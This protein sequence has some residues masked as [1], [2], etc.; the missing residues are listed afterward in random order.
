MYFIGRI[1]PAAIAFFGIALY[2]RF[3]DPVSFGTYALLLSTSFL[4]GT[5]C[6]SWLRVAALRMMGTVVASDEA[7]YAATIAASFAGM[8]VLVSIIL[9]VSLHFYHLQLSAT[10]IALTV[11]GAVMSGWFELN[12]SIAQARLK[13]T[14]YSVLQS[15][16]AIA[17][18][19]AALGLIHIGWKVDALLG[20]FIVGNCVSLF[21]LASWRSALRGA[22]RSAIFHKLFRFGWPSSA[23]SLSALSGTFQRFSLQFF[24]GAGV[25]GIFAAVSDFANQTIGLLIGTAALAGQPLAF[26]ARDSGSPGELEDQLRN[27]A[28]L[29][30]AIGVGS[31]AG[32]IALAQPLANV[33]FGP[34]FRVD[35]GPLIVVFAIATLLGGIRASYFEQGFEIMLKTRPIAILTAL[36]ICFYIGLS[37][38][39]IPRIG[40]MGA[41]YSSLVSEASL[42]IVTMV[43]SRSLLHMPVPIMSFAKMT[44]AALFMAL[45]IQLVP[46]RETI[47][48]VVLAVAVGIAAYTTSFGLLYWRE[49]RRLLAS[50]LRARIV[51]NG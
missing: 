2:T 39:L 37:I 44:A 34:K 48:G 15:A 22:S 21:A 20:G 7:D 40:S 49:V 24:G 26:R 4:V 16:R 41:A 30:Y 19:A 10:T 17:N 18:L 25:L 12:V 38:L 45:C 3:L 29:I 6:F 46:G 32:L 23:S 28:R 42:L 33:Y 9:V 31:T 14:R 50:R 1:L 36:R 11:A 13:L 51:P 47:G 35:A 27:N 43:W 5:T 8:A